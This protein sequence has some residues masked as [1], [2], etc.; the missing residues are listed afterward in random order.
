MTY[1]IW[2]LV[3]CVTVSI[4]TKHDYGLFTTVLFATV[5]IYTVC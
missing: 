1:H 3:H 4:D 5:V 2:A